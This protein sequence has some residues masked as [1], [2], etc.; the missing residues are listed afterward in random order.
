M[1]WQPPPPPNPRGQQPQQPAQ[2]QSAPRQ[3]TYYDLL[4][5]TPAAHPT[6]IRY[7]YRFLAGIY[8]PDN[9]ETGSSDGGRRAAYDAHLCPL[10]K[11]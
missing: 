4:Q 8:H 6:I 5:V 2:Q 10:L 3:Q 11:K 7:A 9:H 1:S